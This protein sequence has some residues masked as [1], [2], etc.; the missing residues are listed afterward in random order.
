V[1]SAGVIVIQQPFAPIGITAILAAPSG[2][3]VTLNSVSGQVDVSVVISPAAF[4]CRHIVG[5]W[6]KIGNVTLNSVDF[7][8]SL[9]APVNLSFHWDTGPTPSGTYVL[10]PG[11]NTVEY[12]ELAGSG[13]PL[14]VNHP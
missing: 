1:A 11:V 10:V 12:G 7:G 14:V 5:A 3:P 4:R 13:I 9:A 2:L 6:I 8:Q